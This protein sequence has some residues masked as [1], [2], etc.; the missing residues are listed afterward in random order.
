M[1]DGSKKCH[2]CGFVWQQ[3]IF[4]VAGLIYK[5]WVNLLVGR[6]WSCEGEAMGKESQLLEAAAAGNL[7]KVE[8]CGP[9]NCTLVSYLGC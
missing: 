1:E 8:V 7:S 9:T 3:C 5:A 2:S 4:G 6:W